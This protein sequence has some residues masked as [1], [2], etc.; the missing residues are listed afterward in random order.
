MAAT[1]KITLR[2]SFAIRMIGQ[3]IQTTPFFQMMS[4]VSNDPTTPWIHPV[5]SAPQV[6]TLKDTVKQYENSIAPEQFQRPESWQSVDKKKYF[7]SILMD[8][9]EG[10]FVFVDLTLAVHKLESIAPENRA[11]KFFKDF[12]SQGYNYL[13]LDA[14]N[15]L[16]MLTALLKDEWKIPSGSY[17]YV[18]DDSVDHLK[19]ECATKFSDLPEVVRHLIEERQIIISQYTQI[20]YKGLSEVFLN[21]NSGVAPNPQEKRNAFGTEWA[22]YVREVRNGDLS[23]MKLIHGENHMRRLFSDNWIAD[24]LCLIRNVTTDKVTGIN[25]LTKN[26]LYTSDFIQSD[27]DYY[28][29]KFQQLSSYITQMIEDQIMSVKAITRPVSCMNLLWMLCNG[30]STYEQA[31][32]AMIEH[33]EFYQRKDDILNDNGRNFTWACGSLGNENNEIRM[34]VLPDIIQKVTSLMPA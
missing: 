1:E 13:T 8:R 12:K 16:K 22:D 5:K 4:Q 18:L 32:D 23:F 26:I 27:A 29:S 6:R 7:T 11:Y 17:W 9:L 33:E 30:I 20:D 31:V 28:T 2:L 19:L 24:A 34:K 14:N 25:Q 3:P 21:V 15:R 10:S